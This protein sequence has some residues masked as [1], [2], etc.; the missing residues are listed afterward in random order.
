MSLRVQ[1]RAFLST[2]E[3]LGYLTREMLEI[4]DPKRRIESYR[5]RWDTNDL[6][7]EPPREEEVEDM[8]AYY[9]GANY[10]YKHGLGR[11]DLMLRS[12]TGPASTGDTNRTPLPMAPFLPVS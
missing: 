5:V 3:R 8:I 12:P 11:E 6:V 9:Q 4:L 1:E 10:L 7:P 2:Y